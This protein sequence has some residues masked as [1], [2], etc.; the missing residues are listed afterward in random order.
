MHESIV[1]A[2]S[3]YNWWRNHC[4]WYEDLHCW[5]LRKYS[6]HLLHPRKVWVVLKITTTSTTIFHWW[7]YK[8]HL[9]PETACIKWGPCQ[10]AMVALYPN[11]AHML[12]CLDLYVFITVG[13]MEEETKGFLF[14]MLGSQRTAFPW[15]LKATGGTLPCFRNFVSNIRFFTLRYTGEWRTLQSYHG[16]GWRIYL[17]YA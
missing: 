4:F 13:F 5:C 11:S 14:K 9:F 16:V 15:F 8:S 17:K 10:W 2:Y 1:L 3:K 12:H 7:L 6:L